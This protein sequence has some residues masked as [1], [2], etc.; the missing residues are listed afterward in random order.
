MTLPIIHQD[1]SLIAVV[2]PSGMPVHRDAFSPRGQ[3]VCLQALRDQIGREVFPVHRLDGATSGVLLFALTKEVLALASK[4]FMGRDVRKVY[5]AVV[6]GWMADDVVC[7]QPLKDGERQL[8]AHTE[9]KVL[10]RIVLPWPNGKYP[11]SRYSYVEVRPT[12]GRYHQ[13]RR[14]ANFLAH[15]IVGDTTHG[16]GEHNRLWR[17]HRDC[18]RLLLHASELRLQHPVSLSDLVLKAA[19]PIDF[20]HQL[21]QLPWTSDVSPRCD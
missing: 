15:P 8:E 5:H 6:R 20:S 12:T 10:K 14:H 11:E 3:V 1:E 2:K 7:D 4:Q 21:D 9:F 19:L 18:H 13:I 16:S 17:S